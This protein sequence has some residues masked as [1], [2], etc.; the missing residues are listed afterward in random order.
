VKGKVKL[1]VKCF[2]DALLVIPRTL[3]ENSGFDPQETLL[4]VQEA[5]CQSKEGDSKAWGVDV[6]TG[7]PMPAA[8]SNV[9]DNYMVKR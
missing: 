1:G 6:L 3:A 7:E 8:V 5:H 4:K 2:G 9:W